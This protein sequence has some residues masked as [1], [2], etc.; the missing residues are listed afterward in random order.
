MRGNISTRQRGEK[1]V[2]Q[3]PGNK[4][5]D[6]IQEQYT[7]LPSRGWRH[8]L[9]MGYPLKFLGLVTLNGTTGLTRFCIRCPNTRIRSSFLQHFS[10]STILFTNLFRSEFYLTLENSGAISLQYSNTHIKR[11]FLGKEARTT[12]RQYKKISKQPVDLCKLSG[13]FMIIL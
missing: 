9:L 2:L 13:F 6:G 1:S 10:P 12:Y 4:N 11:V 3:K 7:N 8:F 5:Y